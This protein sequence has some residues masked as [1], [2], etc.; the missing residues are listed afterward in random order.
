M[1]AA[2]LALS[3]VA[4]RQA[5]TQSAISAAILK[6]RHQAEQAFAS[7]LEQAAQSLQAVVAAPPPGAGTAVD[8]RV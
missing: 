3:A 6:Q 8:I 1:S 2:S 5:Q 4:S 7:L